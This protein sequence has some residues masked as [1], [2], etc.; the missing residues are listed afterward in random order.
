M[1]S[2]LQTLSSKRLVPFNGDRKEFANQNHLNLPKVLREIHLL[3]NFSHKNWF[4]SRAL[5]L[6][7]R[8]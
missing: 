4:Q 5:I 7:V 1:P 3:I 8:L 6:F 2:I